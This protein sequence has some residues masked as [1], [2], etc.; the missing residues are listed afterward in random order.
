[1]N[2]DGSDQRELAPG[3]VAFWSPDGRKIA[4]TDDGGVYVM[5]PDGTEQRWLSRAA[6]DFAPSWS[7]D[8]RQIVF[9]YGRPGRAQHIEI[10]V[11]KIDGSGSRN[12]TRNPGD[13]ISAAWSA[14]LRK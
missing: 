12:L 7:P 6:G 13:D 5:N 2:A 4:F 8:S 14:R 11:A 10:Y 1:M 9:T 3:W